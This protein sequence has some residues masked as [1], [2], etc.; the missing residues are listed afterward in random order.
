MSHSDMIALR[1][2]VQSQC[3]HGLK[4]MARLSEI[5]RLPVGDH[6]AKINRRPRIF[7]S[8]MS[9]TKFSDVTKRVRGYLCNVVSTFLGGSCPPL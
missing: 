3:T 2:H 9:R 7:I 5:L 6:N 4:H 1:F 8:V